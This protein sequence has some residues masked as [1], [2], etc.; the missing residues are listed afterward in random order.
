MIWA[1]LKEAPDLQV[2]GIVDPASTE[3]LQR[4]PE[5]QRAGARVFS[6]VE[7]MLASGQLDALA[8]GTR[9]DSHTPIAIQVAGAGLPLF[10][11]KPVSISLE[12]ARELERAYAGVKSEVVVSHPLR[13]SKLCQMA[14][15]LLEENAIGRPEH[16][17]GINYVPYGNV[18][19]DTWHRDY[20]ITQGLFLQK[21]THDFDYLAYLMGAPIVRVAAMHQQG[22][23]FRDASLQP[24]EGEPTSYYYPEIGQPETGMNEDASSALLHFANGAQGVYTQVFYSKHAAA[25]RGA[26]ISGLRGTLQ[27]DWHKGA[28]HLH[29]HE[30]DRTTTHYPPTGHEHFGGDQVLAENFVAV[31]RG[32]AASTSTLRAG[33]QSVYACLAAKQSAE[34]G[35]FVD[36][37]QLNE[38]QGTA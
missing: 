27:F 15:T 26:T 34:T 30:V 33:L 18:Y 28:L 5:S 25:A 2:T 21:A 9:C 23:V 7:D 29:H 1:F 31:I 38:H 4:L 19:F 17:L 22:R 12:Q 3:A 6:T 11:E 35:Q 20:R 32:E 24:P 8:I 10:L 36:V 16:V 14:K 13:V 37:Q